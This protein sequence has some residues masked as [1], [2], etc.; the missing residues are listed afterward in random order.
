MW[1]FIYFNPVTPGIN[2]KEQPPPQK[3]LF[4]FILNMT[5]IT[6][7]YLQSSAVKVAGIWQHMYFRAE[8][9]QK[10]G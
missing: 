3:I 10:Y 6:H 4:Y 7:L 2:I 5:Q 1:L 8:K 9:K